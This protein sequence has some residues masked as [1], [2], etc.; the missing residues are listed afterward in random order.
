[1]RKLAFLFSLGLALQPV[2]AQA[3]TS[4]KL[5]WMIGRWT[6]AGTSFGAPSQ[7]SL[8]VAPALDGKFVELR[9]QLTKPMSFE[10]RAYYKVKSGNDWE[11]RW[12]DSRGVIFTIGASVDGKTL[13]SNWG[14]AE[15]ERGR[16]VYKLLDDGK[17]EVVDTALAKDGSWR[18][19]A[20]QVFTKAK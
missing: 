11:A 1:M 15:T 3:Q 2:A 8:E 14:S 7:S 5:D 16:T 18:E 17:L 9:Y 12:F 19:F 20:R 13:T 10:G 6:G 4:G